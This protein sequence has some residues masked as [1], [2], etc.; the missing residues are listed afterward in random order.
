MENSEDTPD[1]EA[2]LDEMTEPDEE[3]LNE[4]MDDL[5]ESVQLSQAANT[6]PEGAATTEDEE[7]KTETES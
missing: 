2:I 6:T 1:Y 4:A 7:S 3:D 5:I